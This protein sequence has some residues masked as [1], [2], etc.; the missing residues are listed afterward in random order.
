MTA[1][2][3]WGYESVKKKL[4]SGG[5]LYNELLLGYYCPYNGFAELPP[6]YGYADLKVCHR[7]LVLN[8]G[9][10]RAIQQRVVLIWVQQIV[11]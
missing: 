3:I 7:L 1:A 6:K 8:R 4:P 10:F 5:C 2:H 11:S 9:D